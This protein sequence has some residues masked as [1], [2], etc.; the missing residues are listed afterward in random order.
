MEKGIKGYLIKSLNG[1]ALGLF[2]S[3]IIGLILK[4][5][6][7]YSG[8][9]SLSRFGQI[10]QFLMG[11]AIGASVAY[12]IGAP[13]LGIFASIA[14]GAIGAGTISLGEAGTFVVKVGEPSGSFVA[15]LI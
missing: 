13:P 1:M 8:L 4:Q 5:I 2:S 6:G 11:P 14:V 7:D 15:V 12:S 9:E 3:L 10:A